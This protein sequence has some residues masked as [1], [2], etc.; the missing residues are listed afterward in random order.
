MRPLLQIACCLLLLLTAPLPVSAGKGSY[1][2]YETVKVKAGKKALAKLKKA[3][4]EAEP[5][6]I[7]E[8][9]DER[10]VVDAPLEIAVDHVVV[11]GRAA[12]ES[13]LDF[14][15]YAGR[16]PAIRITGD[17]VVLEHLRILGPPAEGVFAL[18]VRRL[19][20][21]NVR[22]GSTKAADRIEAPRIG[23]SPIAVVDSGDVLIERS[24]VEFVR[25]LAGIYIAQSENVVVR[26]STVNTC[27]Y[28]IEIEN[29]R[30]VDVHHNYL[31]CDSGVLVFNRPYRTMSAG[32]IRIYRN[33][34]LGDLR[35]GGERQ[36]NGLRGL[37]PSGTGLFVLATDAVDVF[38]N[39]FEEN[40]SSAVTVASYNLFDDDTGDD[41]FDP[42]SERIFLW[43]NDF[44]R[45]ALSTGLSN[46]GVAWLRTLVTEL[47]RLFRYTVPAVLIAVDDDPDKQVDGE[48]PED[49]RVCLQENQTGKERFGEANLYQYLAGEETPFAAVYRFP[50][51][52]DFYDCKHEKLPRVKPRRP[53]GMGR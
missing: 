4:L 30:G 31:A 49:L 19:A 44:R 11:R 35:D 41:D 14:S 20:I 34:I 1:A 36:G 28:A 33:A 39:S 50:S 5:G 23:G 7:I 45:N 25:R 10:I 40:R 6:T 37:V 29:S 18:G 43:D 27:E 51:P 26:R 47:F 32:R 53:R 38:R 24:Q 15:T 3:F 12:S 52:P 48:L 8:L 9:P 16:D 2:G 21:R 46:E 22:V 42:Y 13:I 17:D